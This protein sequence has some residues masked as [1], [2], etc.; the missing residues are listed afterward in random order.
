MT[1][2]TLEAAFRALADALARGDLDAFY[3]AMLPDAVIM[4]EDLPF[5]VDTDGFK[6]HIAFHGADNWEGFA[7][8]PSD[9][10][11]AVAGE[12]GAVAGFAMFRGKPRGA[13]FRLR[14]MM[15]SQGWTRTRGNW[16]LASWHQSPIVG[17]VN[18]QSPG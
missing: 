3:G 4:D 14:P 8:K 16:R 5:R 10:R 1:T 7:W 13:G 2:A 18:G 6:A 11:Y 15:F 12:T 17:H 9:M